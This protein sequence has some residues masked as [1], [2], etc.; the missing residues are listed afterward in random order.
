VTIEHRSVID[1]VERTWVVDVA[2]AAKVAAWVARTPEALEVDLTGMADFFP[3]WVLVGSKGE[4]PARCSGCDAV[5]GPTRGALRCVK[6]GRKRDVDGLLWL[7]HIPTLARPERCFRRR[8]Q[9]LREAGFAEVMADDAIYLLVPLTV[10]YPAEWPNVEPIVRYARRWLDALGI[11]HTSGTHH[12]IHNGRA[13]I[14]S[15]GQWI[16]EPIHVVLQ[17]RMVNHIASLLKIAAGQR[18]GEAFIGRV[19]HRRWE[20]EA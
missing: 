18:P 6:C 17:Q 13:C 4:R 19:H 3:H 10:R 20:P 16:A 14:Y 7:G 9:A 12:L 5:V 2:A 8:Q 15:W 1:D 11:P